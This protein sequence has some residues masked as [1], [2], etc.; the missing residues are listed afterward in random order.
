MHKKRILVV[1]GLLGL[2]FTAV[3]LRLLQLQVVCGEAYEAAARENRVQIRIIPP[4]RGRILDRAGR[5]LAEDRPRWTVTLNLGQMLS[6]AALAHALAQ[7]TGRDPLSLQPTLGRGWGRTR[8]LEF[9]AVREQTLGKTL[10]RVA[11]ITGASRERMETRLRSIERKILE[12]ESRERVRVLGLALSRDTAFRRVLRRD[13]RAREKRLNEWMRAELS[14]DEYL[15]MGGFRWELLDRASETRKA[16]MRELAPRVGKK[17]R[18]LLKK[19]SEVERATTRHALRAVARRDHAILEAF[20]PYRTVLALELAME[21]LPG[22]SVEARPVRI[23]PR[24]V[25]ACHV[26]GSVGYLGWI[27]RGG[28]DVNLYEERERQGWYFER[29]SSFLD[30][31]EYQALESRGEFLSDLFGKTGLEKDLDVPLRGGRGARVVECDRRRRVQKNLA[32][33]PP[34]H[35]RTFAITLDAELQEAAQRAFRPDHC[36]A[37]AKGEGLR[38]AAVVLEL[39]SGAVRVLLSVPGYDPNDLVPPVRPEKARALFT[40]PGRPMLNRALAGC[41]EPGS[42]FKTVTALAARSEGLSDGNTRIFCEGALRAHDYTFRCNARYGHGTLGLKGA[43]EQSCNV[44]FY[45]LGDLLG[46]RLG[47]WAETFGFGAPTGID[48]PGERGGSLPYG[49]LPGFWIQLAI[50][51]NMTAT[52]LQVARLAA[53]VACDGRLPVPFLLSS[54]GPGPVLELPRE[55]LAEVREGFRRVVHG[56]RGT[57]RLALLRKLNAAGKTGTAETGRKRNG[58]FLN[59]AWFAGYAPHDAPRFAVAVVVEDVPSG[60]HGGDIAA[61]IA[62]EILKACLA[63]GEGR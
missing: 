53:C 11:E 42:T 32:V 34:R 12:E 59:H 2:G 31:E 15:L 48:L 37:L 36:A 14:D 46:H 30:R 47:V 38:G 58:V 33:T 20:F 8:A 35:G 6:P 23:Y 50:G 28:E 26:L 63:T 29:V 13:L 55:A 44:Y 40:D 19:L 21:E 25:C 4:L 60:V 39:P 1:L 16:W 51:Q 49:V 27:R 5:V 57:A 9:R 41:Y 22:V 3:T 18:E 17:A 56:G 45:R 62:A 54:R 10:D 52:V 43:L 24:G 7:G 61:P